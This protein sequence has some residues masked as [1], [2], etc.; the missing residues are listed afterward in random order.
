MDK[1]TSVKNKKFPLLIYS[2]Y[3]QI[4]RGL[5]ITLILLGLVLTATAIL[6]WLIRPRGMSRDITPLLIAGG[7]IF[8]LG[9]ARYLLTR[10]F[11]RLAYV[12]CTARNIKIQTP[13]IPIV[14][15][16]KRIADTRPTTLRELFPPEK[17]KGMRRKMLEELWGETVIVVELKGYPMSKA[18][19]R[20]LMGP[21]LLMPR[22]TGFVFMVKDW[23][24][25]NRQIA[26]YLEQWRARTSKS[27]S[28][29]QRGYYTGR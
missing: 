22:G 4:H 20:Q 6:V 19:L 11:S 16:Y 3:H 21:F 8:V 24:G 18:W 25:L 17:Q 9:V 13:A 15:S 26:D 14:F 28:A 10:T 1:S 27:V 29:S 5:S 7:L 12:Q 2:R 23:M